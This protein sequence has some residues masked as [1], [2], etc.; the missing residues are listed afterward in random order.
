MGGR[1]RKGTLA[2]AS[3]F[4]EEK[5]D[6][7]LEKIKKLQGETVAVWSHLPSLYRAEKI[8]NLV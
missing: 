6:P 1:L 7:H 5:A 8:E 3:I 2:P 4:V